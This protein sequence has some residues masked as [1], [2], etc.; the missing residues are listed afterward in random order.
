MM[1]SIMGEIPDGDTNCQVPTLAIK[2]F[3]TSALTGS[4]FGFW[5]YLISL[6][7]LDRDYNVVW[8]VVPTAIGLCLGVS[9]IVFLKRKRTHIYRSPA[10]SIL[11]TLI[12]NFNLFF[13]IMLDLIAGICASWLFFIV[14][15]LIFGS[16]LTRWFGIVFV[17]I[18]VVIFVISLLY[19]ARW[20]FLSGLIYFEKKSNIGEPV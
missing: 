19:V 16:N 1:I 5:G 13:G 18:A 6:T 15:S 11:T 4:V 2:Y 14:F 7:L 17:P 9:T 12:I 3:I 20:C 8:A 10:F